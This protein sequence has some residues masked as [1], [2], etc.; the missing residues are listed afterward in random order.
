MSVINEGITRFKQVRDED[1]SC[2]AIQETR[3]CK[4]SWTE[5]HLRATLAV[6]FC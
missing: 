2:E 1:C 6:R 4:G 5:E 3:A